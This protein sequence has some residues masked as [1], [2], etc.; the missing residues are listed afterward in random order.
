MPLDVDAIL[1]RAAVKVDPP[2]RQRRGLKGFALLA[3]ASLA[4]LLLVRGGEPLLPG[5]PGFPGA[6]VAPVVVAYAD[7]ETPE[8][9]NLAVLPTGNPDITVLWFYQ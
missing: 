1:S 4:A 8:G 3:A 2:V 6:P 5:S 9:S 7:F